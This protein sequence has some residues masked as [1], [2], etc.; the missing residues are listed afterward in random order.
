MPNPDWVWISS[1]SQRVPSESRI[2]YSFQD[3]SGSLPWSTKVPPEESN[4]LG[5]LS[6]L[7]RGCAPSPDTPASEGV[8]D[9]VTL[10]KEGFWPARLPALVRVSVSF[11]AFG[12][13]ARPAGALVGPRAHPTAHS[14]IVVCRTSRLNTGRSGLGYQ[15]SNGL[16]SDP[17]NPRP[18]GSPRSPS[19]RKALV[20]PP[21]PKSDPCP[22]PSS[23]RRLRT[24][25]SRLREQT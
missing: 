13:W 14:R 8:R 25:H 23:S 1:R 7:G 5:R 16:R 11:I 19:L 18:S 21:L 6:G 24:R 9:A 12:V 15:L 3:P 10:E 4:D 2:T 20:R 17:P 22:R